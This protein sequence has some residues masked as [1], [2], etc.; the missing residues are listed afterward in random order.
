MVDF[1]R[2]QSLQWRRNSMIPMTHV[3]F[4]LLAMLL[5]WVYCSSLI[6]IFLHTIIGLNLNI[7]RII[8]ESL[9][10]SNGAGG[11]D[12][13]T[14]SQTRQIA[15]RAGRFNTAYSDGQVGSYDCVHSSFR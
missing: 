1:R 4:W 5:E 15:G 2:I 8:F 13:L 7:R 11:R 14:P 12:L 9:M 6:F 3:M 10:K